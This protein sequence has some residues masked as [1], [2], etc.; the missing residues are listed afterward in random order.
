MENVRKYTDI[1][2]VT[3]KARR[4]YLVSEPNYH[5]TNFFSKNLLGIEIKRTQIFTKKTSLFRSINIRIS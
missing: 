2:L 3:K 5:T 1:K 4:I